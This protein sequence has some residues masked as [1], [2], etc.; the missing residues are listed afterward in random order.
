MTCSITMHRLQRVPGSVGT[1]MTLARVVNIR[2]MKRSPRSAHTEGEAVRE[3][4]V[5]ATCT[6]VGSYDEV[7]YCSVCGEE[8]SREEKVIDAL[9][10]SFTSYV[11]DNNATCTEDGTG[12]RK[13]RSLRCYRHENGRGFRSRPMT[14]PKS[15]RRTAPRIGMNAAAATRSTTK[16]TTAAAPRRASNLQ[17]AKSAALEYGD[18]AEHNYVDG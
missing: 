3:N 7:V 9:G 16:P 13:V 17:S 1:P 10:H 18:F 8:L 2:R 12:D 15:G 14:G 5:D 6:V 11:S 4:E